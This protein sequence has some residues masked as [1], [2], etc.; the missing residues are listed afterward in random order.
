MKSVFLLQHT[1]ESE[2]DEKLKLEE[3]KIIGIYSS[4]EKAECVIQKYKTIQGFNKYPED[5]F[6]IDEYKIDK[7]HWQEGFITWDS[8]LGDWTEDNT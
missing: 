8:Q 4:K 5:C 6:T 1:Y 3:T 2:G 7:N